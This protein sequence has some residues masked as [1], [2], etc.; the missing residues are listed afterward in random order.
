M[1]ENIRRAIQEGPNLPNKLSIAMGEL[2]RDAR[3]ERGISQDELAERVYRRRPS[4]SDI[5]NGKMY[6][7]IETLIYIASVLEKPLLY[8]IP[9]HFRPEAEVSELSDQ[10]KEAV[11]IFRQLS[12]EEQR[13]ALKQLRAF[14]E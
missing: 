10:E 1:L 14:L 13:T 4:I 3:K 9:Q 8:F 6:A 7:D 2:I 5:E 11:A 12:E